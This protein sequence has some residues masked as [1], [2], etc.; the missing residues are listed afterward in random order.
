MQ[1][2]RLTTATAA[3]EDWV[4]ALRR[5][6]HQHPELG[7]EELWTAHYISK[8]L[9]EMGIPQQTGVA[10]TGVVG[11]IQGNHPGKTIAL[12]AD[13][14][15]LPLTEATGLAYVSLNPGKMHACGHDAH[16]AIQLGAA[17]LLNNLKKDFAGNIKLLFQPAE[18]TTGGARPMIAAGCMNNPVVDYVLGL[19]V[20]PL[21][22]AGQILIRYG[23]ITAASDSLNI[24]ISGRPTHAAYPEEGIDAIVIAAQVITAMQTILSRNISPLDA[25]VITI[26]RINGGAR[27]N[28]IAETVNLSGTIRSLDSKTRNT[29]KAILNRTVTGI[30]EAM[31]G[32]CEITFTEGYLPIINHDKVMKVVEL[33]AE[34]L[35]GKTNVLTKEQASLGVDDFSCFA[36]QVPGAFYYLGCGNK[37][38]GITIPGHSPEF[39]IDEACLITGVKLQVMSA[40]SLLKQ[41]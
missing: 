8:L 17:R 29:I 34:T 41:L 28:I 31:G 4:V 13:M 39:Q 27:D 9:T 38:L 37:Q 5:E 6:F 11:L 25:G 26:G 36:H 40:L 16:L 32:S 33:N 21:A 10:G 22:E 14:D 18:E 30:C 35:L 19:H 20:T 24:T 1:I 12:R 2:E 7:N 3:I 23:Q 15:G